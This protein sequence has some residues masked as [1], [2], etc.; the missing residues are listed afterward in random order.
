MAS[1]GDDALMHD[2]EM[3]REPSLPQQALREFDIVNTP[4]P[5]LLISY[6]FNGL[7]V[8]VIWRT[9]KSVNPPPVQYLT[10]SSCL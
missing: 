10:R 6:K 3:I 4:V 8:A 1:H 2:G 7:L 9:T 5:M